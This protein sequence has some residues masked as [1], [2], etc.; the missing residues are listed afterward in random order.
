[1]HGTKKIICVFAETVV[2]YTYVYKKMEE[3][4]S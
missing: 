4:A 1:M 2:Q 3:S